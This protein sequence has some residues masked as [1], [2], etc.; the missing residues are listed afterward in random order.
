MKLPLHERIL[1][2]L[3]V[4]ALASLITRLLVSGLARVYK[5]F[6]CYLIVDLLE[7]VAPLFIGIGNLY[8]WVFFVFQCIKLC[9]YVLIVFELY[10]VLLRDLKGIAQR[11]KRYSVVALV[12]SVMLSVFVVTALPLPHSLL[13]KLFYV[14]IPIMSILVLFIV[15]ITVFLAYYPVPLH[16]NAL[17]YATGYVVYFIS[18]AALLFMINLYPAASVRTFSTILLYVGPGCVVFWTIL[19]SRESEQRTLSVGSGWSP[20]E[21]RQQVL[22][23]LR[24]LNDSLLRAR[25]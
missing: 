12:I 17:V 9:F 4:I 11:A 22:L 25:K 15:L 2:L 7:T 14:E 1:L 5:Y 19:L 13:R 20:P 23:R 24:E 3:E 18:K 8:F 16:R 10:S 6:F 21:R